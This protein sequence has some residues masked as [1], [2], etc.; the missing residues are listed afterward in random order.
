VYPTTRTKGVDRSLGTKAPRGSSAEAMSS[1]Q[2]PSG[3][4]IT[5]TEAGVAWKKTREG[6]FALVGEGVFAL[7]G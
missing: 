6:V 3:K 7:L 5:E 2:V 4:S 1:G